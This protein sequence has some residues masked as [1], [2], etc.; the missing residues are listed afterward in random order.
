MDLSQFPTFVIGMHE[1]EK[2][3]L[4]WFL[5]YVRKSYTHRKITEIWYQSC[6]FTSITDKITTD[7]DTKSSILTTQPLIN[8][9]TFLHLRSIL[10]LG[11]YVN[12][13]VNVDALLEE[14]YVLMLTND[15]DVKKYSF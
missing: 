11:I 3:E 6:F 2:K 5:K 13:I 15:F 10:F 4:Y 1:I 8:F 7:Y 9:T 12:S 14:C